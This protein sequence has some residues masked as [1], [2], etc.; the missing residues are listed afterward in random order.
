[1]THNVILTY[2]SGSNSIVASP[3]PVT[4]QEGDHIQWTSSIGQWRVRFDSGTPFSA[5]QIGGNASQTQSLGPVLVGTSGNDYK[6]A[7]AIRLGSGQTVETD[8]HVIVQ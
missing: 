3:D 8:P 6:Y 2:N 4:V 5:T 1:M 7:A